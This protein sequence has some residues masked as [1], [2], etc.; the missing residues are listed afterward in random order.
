MATF[1]T[2]AILLLST[3]ASHSLD[4]GML[5]TPA[6]GFSDACLGGAE[7][8]RLNATE[9]QAV[10]TSFVSTGKE[11]HTPFVPLTVEIFFCFMFVFFDFEQC[12]VSPHQ[13]S[14]F[15][16]T[17]TRLCIPIR[18]DDVIA[19]HRTPDHNTTPHVDRSCITRLH[20]DEFR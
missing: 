5:R 2:V 8:T 13:G 17:S 7:D 19:L 15:M 9:L 16:L 11:T 6:M 3:T 18:H 20:C 10:A 4:N 12:G 14:S 1:R